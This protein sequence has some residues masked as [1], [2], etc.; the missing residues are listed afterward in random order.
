M[1][2]ILGAG[3]RLIQWI[4]PIKTIVNDYRRP[5]PPLQGEDWR[6]GWVSILM[7]VPIPIPTFPLKGKERMAAERFKGR[8]HPAAC[9]RAR[10]GALPRLLAGGESSRATRA[11]CGGWVG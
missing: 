3:D 1:E 6:W 8:S 9:T 2:R 7:V 11:R 4:V 5:L 10:P